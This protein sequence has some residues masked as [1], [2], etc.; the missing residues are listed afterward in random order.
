V[1]QQP[2]APRQ[3]P[4][5]RT[6]PS[7]GALFPLELFLVAG[8]NTVEVRAPPRAAVARCQIDEL[9]WMREP[10]SQ[11]LGPGV[12]WYRPGAHDLQRL[13]NWPGVRA[14]L[15]ADDATAQHWLAAAPAVL[16][17]AA[18]VER[19]QSRF[20]PARGERYALMEA[21]C[22]VQNSLL[23]AEALE[24]GAVWVG[25][26]HDQGVANALGLPPAL[27]PLA[28]IPVGRVAPPGAPHE[29]EKQHEEMM[30]RAAAETAAQQPRRVPVRDTEH[31]ID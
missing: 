27:R 1:T 12:W 6:A 22:S 30:T 26:F 16:V 2:E 11:G 7:A 28:V 21:G 20:G 31:D 17:L 13:R 8:E 18:A 23:M 24:L 3:A 29:G 14:A 4:K 5:G 10:A 9:T 19:S 15:A 25:A